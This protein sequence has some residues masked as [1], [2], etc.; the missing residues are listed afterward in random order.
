MSQPCLTSKLFKKILGAVL[1]GSLV[2]RGK[3]GNEGALAPSIH[4]QNKLV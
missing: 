4:K 2:R 1:E 3:F